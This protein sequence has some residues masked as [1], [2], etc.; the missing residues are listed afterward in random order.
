SKVGRAD[1]GYELRQRQREGH[2]QQRSQASTAKR[3][4]VLP[5]E[6]PKRRKSPQNATDTGADDGG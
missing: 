6:P 2:N 1:E 5:K 3:R 4:M